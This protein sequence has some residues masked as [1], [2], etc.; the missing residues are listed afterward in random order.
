MFAS[1][2]VLSFDDVQ[3]QTTMIRMAITVP[4]MRC[5]YISTLFEHDRA[6]CARSPL[7]QSR[8][9]GSGEYT[10]YK[11]PVFLRAGLSTLRR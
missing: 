5:R 3:E 8:R 2:Y 9:P 4:C 1:V 11:R 7:R 6:Q 10:K